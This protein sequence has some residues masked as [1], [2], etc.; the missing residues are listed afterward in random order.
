MLINCINKLVLED[1]GCHLW[2]LLLIMKTMIIKTFFVHFFSLKLSSRL[3]GDESKM[4][5][6]SERALK[7]ANPNASAEI[8]QHI[9]SLVNLSTVK[10]M[11]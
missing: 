10:E 11:Q 8:A 5:D 2:V 3:T 6:M 4:A 7:A 1:V 9:L